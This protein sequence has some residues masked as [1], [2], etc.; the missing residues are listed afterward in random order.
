MQ[1]LKDLAMKRVCLSINQLIDFNKLDIPKTL[2]DTCKKFWKPIFFEIYSNQISIDDDDDDINFD[3]ITK[4]K[5]S[6]LLSR[7][8]IPELSSRVNHICMKY[9][10]VVLKYEPNLNNLCLLCFIKVTNCVN[11][12]KNFFLNN[13]VIKICEH[14]VVLFNGVMP[15]IKKEK[16][17][18]DNCM[19]KPLFRILTQRDCHSLSEYHT[20]KRRYNSDSD[21]NSDSDLSEIPNFNIKRI[22]CFDD[23]L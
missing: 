6:S 18:C 17:W 19:V 20:L 21:S 10:H 5:L 7:T 16:N 9:I 8:I 3:N 11:L 4:Q 1:S 2:I 14:N 13:S 12:P 23:I 22:L 15:L